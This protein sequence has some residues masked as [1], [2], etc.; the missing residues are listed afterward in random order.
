M[1]S[2]DGEVFQIAWKD[3]AMALFMSSVSD[4]TKKIVH[5]R[6]RPAKTAT[7]AHT[8]RLVFGDAVVKDL[9][10]SNYIDMYNHFA[11]GVDISDQLRSYYN[12]QNSHWKSWKALWHF[13]LN[14]TTTT[15]YLQAEAAWYGLNSSLQVD[16]ILP[17]TLACKLRASK[18]DQLLG[19]RFAN[20]MIEEVWPMKLVCQNWIYGRRLTD[21]F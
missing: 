17:P 4:G 18:I 20:Q 21:S 1:V 12:T 5:Q 10:I 15:A 13:L 19:R 16:S 8:S 14:T 9:T 3:Q 11:N 7:N 6:R 2:E